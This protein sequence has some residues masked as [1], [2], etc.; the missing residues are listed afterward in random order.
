MLRRIDVDTPW[1]S[2]EPGFW[3]AEAPLGRRSIVYG[4]NGSGK[5]T[6][7]ELLLALSNPE[8]GANALW[9]DE[10]LNRISLYSSA[11]NPPIP[12]SVFTRQWVEE[13]LTSFLDGDNAAAIVT[14]GREAID[15]KE[16]EE[17]LTSKIADL[18]HEKLAA[19]SLLHQNRSKVEKIIRSVQDDIATQLQPS[20]YK[21]FSKNQYNAPRV[22]AIIRGFSNIPPDK[23]AYTRA[24]QH[25]LEP[26]PRPI[27]TIADV[28][29]AQPTLPTEV[30]ELL[31]KTPT[32]AMIEELSK[33]AAVQKWVGE[34]LELHEGESTCLFCN[35]K[36]TEARRSQ[37]AAHFDASWARIASETR[38]LLDETENLIQNLRAWNHSLP[39]VEV[40]ASSFQEEYSAAHN[41]LNL[42]VADRIRWIEKLKSALEAKLSNPAAV[43]QLEPKDL[44]S[45]EI[46]LG[47]LRRIIDQHNVEASSGMAATK[48]RQQTILDYLVGRQHA[49]LIALDAEV[50]QSGTRVENLSQLLEDKRA[51][52]ERARQQRFSTKEMAETLTLD[53]SRIYG[54]NHLNIQVTTDGKAYSCRR[55]HEKATRLSDGERMTISLLYF[56]RRLQD[57]SQETP[58]ASERIVVID[59]PCSSLDRESI[60]ATHQWL[61]DSLAPYGQ[62]IIFTHDFGLLRL[63]LK[64][65]KNQWTTSLKKLRD[66]DA[67][68]GRFPR[69]TFLELYASQSDGRRCTRIGSMP[70]HLLNATS[71][72]NYLFGKVMEGV[73]RGSDDDHLFLLPNASRRLLEVFC[74]FKVPDRTDFLPALQELVKERSPVNGQS[75]EPFRDVYDFCN[76][77][78][79]GEGQ[80]VI[81]SLD[82]RVVHRQIV[83]SMQ[84]LRAVDRQHFERMCAACGVD[85]D[86]LPAES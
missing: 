86:D 9:E 59:D 26:T 76:R 38:N 24:L 29:T 25:L 3:P 27:D 30:A 62:Y 74:S 47:E 49:S 75:I 31:R 32:S 60:F 17:D 5:S 54:K 1:R 79:H 6:I 36:I 70:R 40:V 13:N 65:H 67:A 58:P 18:D 52:L 53:L 2:L 73:R 72:Y 8:A 55:G 43:F 83:R 14:L 35:S 20:N 4:H 85:K 41:I 7:S 11:S 82:E 71:E 34:G 69:A 56:L 84:F 12:V 61:L 77:F 63:F 23:D 10:S 66:G 57:E 42:E 21:Q 64:S 19:Q 15:A 68:E 33:N 39:P 46:K 45:R 22:G 81:E 28:P 78:S 37:L 80:E 44:L 48:S 51:E 50:K 16:A